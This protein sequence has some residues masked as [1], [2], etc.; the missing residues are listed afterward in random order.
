M[1]QIF[2]QYYPY[3]MAG[4]MPPMYYTNPIMVRPGMIP[5]GG[6]VPMPLPG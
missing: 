4:T 2:R 6:M 3:P 5:P 1:A